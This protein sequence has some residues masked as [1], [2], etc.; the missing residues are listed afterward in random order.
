MLSLKLPYFMLEFF[1]KATQLNHSIKILDVK[2]LVFP[3]VIAS[4]YRD[5]EALW[6]AAHTTAE[7]RVLCCDQL[8]LVQER[9][10]PS[11]TGQDLDHSD[12]SCINI[13]PPSNDDDLVKHS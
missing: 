2:D 5:K 7:A 11:E 13:N 3:Q 1:K 12:P 6:F 4:P 9:R 8:H 10:C